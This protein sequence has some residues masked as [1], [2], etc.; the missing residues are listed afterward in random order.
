[1]HVKVFHEN[2]V[3]T[4]QLYFPDQFLD[5]LYADVDPYRTH[6]QM[7]TPGTGRLLDRLRNEEDGGFLADQSKPMTLGRE[8]NVATAEATIGV[9]TLGSLG[10]APLFR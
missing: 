9:A 7:T 1:V 4:T 5:Q 6:R 3:L 2:K 10:V 8:G